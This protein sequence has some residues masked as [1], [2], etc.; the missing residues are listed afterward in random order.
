[1]KTN[2]SAIALALA[3]TST[4]TKFSVSGDGYLSENGKQI[5]ASK[6]A[7]EFQ[8]QGTEFTVSDGFLSTSDGQKVY[9]GSVGDILYGSQNGDS[10]FSIEN[11]E[12]KWSHG[13]FYACPLDQLF[14]TIRLGATRKDGVTPG[15]DCSPI[16]LTQV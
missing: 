6:G 14:Q 8:N 9:V 15:D 13:G 3:A 12:L 10:G 2:F 4:A 16:V 7:V 1:M 5:S 11:G